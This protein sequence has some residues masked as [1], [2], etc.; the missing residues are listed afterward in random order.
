M[1]YKQTGKDQYKDI[2]NISENMLDRA[3]DEFY[4]LHHDVGFTWRFTSVANYQLTGNE[5]SKK[6]ALM[7]AN[8]LAD[9][10]LSVN[11]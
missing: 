10:I 7:A 6:R 1:L 3:I 11:I 9:L 4:G 5:K 2:A 8:L